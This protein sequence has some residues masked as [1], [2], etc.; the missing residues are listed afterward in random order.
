VGTPKEL[1]NTPTN[2]FVAGFIGSP[3]M[4]FVR[5]RVDAGGTVVAGGH[6]RLQPPG[7]LVQAIA[8]RGLQEVWVGIRPEHL[9]LHGGT[10]ANASNLVRSVVEVVE[11][12]GSTT[13]MQRRQGNSA[14]R[15]V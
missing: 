8:Q 5:A 14:Y 4:N 13:I 11:P 9:K 6:F 12:Q 1:F 10:E 7:A 3:S 15:P 2:R